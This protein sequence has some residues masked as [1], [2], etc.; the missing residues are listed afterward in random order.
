MLPVNRW[1]VQK[2][3]KV[4]AVL[5]RTQVRA[6]KS[7]VQSM[8]FDS[9]LWEP[10]MSNSTTCPTLTVDIIGVNAKPGAVTVADGVIPAQ[11]TT[12]ARGAVGASVAAS[13]GGDFEETLGGWAPP[14][15]L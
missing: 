7:A 6:L 1:G 8:S 4:P 10:G 12:T 2:K 13:E 15:L 9:A 3:L 5:K 14:L 11:G